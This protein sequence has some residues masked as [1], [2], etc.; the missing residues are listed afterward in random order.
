MNELNFEAWG[1]HKLG[2]IQRHQV[3]DVPGAGNPTEWTRS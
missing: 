3:S 2:S 1:V